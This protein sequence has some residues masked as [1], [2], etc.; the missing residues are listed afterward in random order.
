MGLMSNYFVLEAYNLSRKSWSKTG[1]THILN[2]L[3][4]NGQQY[5]V[6]TGYGL[7]LPLKPVPLNGEVVSSG[8]GEFR[9]REVESEFGNFIFQMKLKYRDEDWVNGYV[10]D[11]KRPLKGLTELNEVQQ[12]IVESPYSPFNKGAL[13]TRL[14][15][16]GNVILTG[17]TLTQRVNGKELK[18]E[19]DP[20]KFQSLPASILDC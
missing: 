8:N 16:D 19:I 13:V 17:E 18:E 9:V 3:T 15:D 1:K 4:H 7:N 2:L 10:F 12:I 20:V 11:S 6:D 5:V 14:T